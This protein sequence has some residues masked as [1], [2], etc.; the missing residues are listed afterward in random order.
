M[1][2][3]NLHKQYDLLK[4]EINERIHTVLDHGQYILGSEVTEL[5]EKLADYVGVKHCIGVANGTDALMIAMMA[6]HIKPGDEVITSPFT[7]IANGEMIALLAQNPYL[8]ILMLTLTILMS[9]N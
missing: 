7:F 2:F 1:Q 5:E 9:V 3:I 6:L 8:S 4:S